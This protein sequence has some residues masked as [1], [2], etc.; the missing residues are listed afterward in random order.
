MNK[1][2]LYRKYRP[3]KFNE[4]IGQN[5]IVKTLASSIVNNNRTHAYI[6]A[7][8]KGSG[9]TTV[10]K[11]FSKAINCLDSSNGDAC[12]QCSN[13]NA[14]NEASTTDFV[15]LDAASNNGVEE[16]RNIINLTNYLP[17]KLK[18]KVYIIDEAH[19]LTTNAWNALLKTIEDPPPYVVFIFATTE[20]H[21]I[22]ATIISRCQRF[23]FLKLQLKDLTT[24]LNTVCQKE[25]IKID[26]DAISII[27]RMA[28]GA[29][30][31]ALSILDQVSNYSGNNIKCDH[32]YEIF[33]LTSID[34]KIDFINKILSKN[35]N[36]VI[37]IYKTLFEKGINITVFVSDL[38]DILMDKLIFIKTNDNKL[39][40]ILSSEQLDKI[41]NSINENSLLSL[42]NLLSEAL[43]KIKGS[44]NP[45][46]VFEYYVLKSLSIED[47]SHE[48]TSQIN[49]EIKASNLNINNSSSF[50]NLEVINIDK[51]DLVKSEPSEDKWANLKNEIDK[52]NIEKAKMNNHFETTKSNESDLFKTKELSLTKELYDDIN[53]VKHQNIEEIVANQPTTEFLFANNDKT[54]PLEYANFI[55]F[56]KNNQDTSKNQTTNKLIDNIDQDEKTKKVFHDY[57]NDFKN[58]FFA[59]A[60][61]HDSNIKNELNKKLESLKE[62]ASFSDYKQANIFLLAEKFLISSNNGAVLLFDNKPQSINFNNIAN[63]IDFNKYFKENFKCSKTIL[64]IDKKTAILYKDEFK[65][66]SKKDIKDVKILIDNDDKKTLLLDILNDSED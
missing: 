23:D 56:E 51:T 35:S 10:A 24:L 36:E 29:A 16:I 49:N 17:N 27:A 62:I 6:F 25:N 12:N 7:G 13:C 65:K 41:N 39:L 19:M 26:S 33:G 66:M 21:K 58:N 48:D 53:T 22:P 8:N 52:K 1:I 28:D 5:A 45:K 34:S 11:I 3:L 63:D 50:S 40:S 37:N 57:D 64:G 32:I 4:V 44:S 31:D 54:K 59:I 18:Y 46:F 38:L 20:Y 47:S 14:I 9:K 61:N 15:E 43:N 30:R 60:A 42:I 2:A 55:E